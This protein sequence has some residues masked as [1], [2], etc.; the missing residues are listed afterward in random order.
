[1]VFIASN[2]EVV[3]MLRTEHGSSQKTGG[4]RAARLYRGEAAKLQLKLIF[5]TNYTTTHHLLTT[6]HCQ[7]CIRIDASFVKGYMRLAEVS[8]SCLFRS[9]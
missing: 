2:E 3:K 8:T 9:R 4:G 5:T 6:E 7:E 1:M